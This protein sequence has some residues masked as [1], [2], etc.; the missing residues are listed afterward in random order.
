MAEK[1]DQRLTAA[2]N[3]GE[4]LPAVPT[5]G[6]HYLPFS[7]AGNLCYLAGQ[8]S[9]APAGRPIA[10][11]VTDAE[12]GAVAARSCALNHLALLRERCGGLDNVRCWHKVTVFVNA[13]SGYPDSPSVGNGYSDL[14]VDVFG[15]EAGMHARSAISVA[16]LPLGASVEVEAIVELKD[17]ALAQRMIP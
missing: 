2:L 5:P 4:A 9:I 12:V 16:G 3:P 6:G 17:P 13:E 10:G 7:V 11:K 15:A 1:P 8:I 14:V